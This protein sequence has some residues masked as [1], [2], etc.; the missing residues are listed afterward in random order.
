MGMA[1]TGTDTTTRTPCRIRW[2]VWAG[3][4]RLART[5]TMRGTWGYDAACTEHDWDSRTGGAT[6]RYVEFAVWLHKVEHGGA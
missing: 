2:F 1:N 5:A 3:G 4:Q 6:R